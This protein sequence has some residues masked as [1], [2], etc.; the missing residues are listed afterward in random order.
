MRK[1]LFLILFFLTHGFLFA[2]EKDYPGSKDHPVLSRYPG[3]RIV[4]YY[5]KEFEEFS[6]LLGPAKDI[7]TAKRKNL[8]GKL[9]YIKYLC[10]PNKTTLEVYK[11]YELALMKAGFKILYK[12]RADGRSDVGA[13]SKFLEEVS[14]IHVGVTEQPSFY[15]S[16][17]SPDEKIFI[18]LFVTYHFDREPKVILSVIEPKPMEI[19]LV[20]AE[21]ITAETMEAQIKETGKVAIYSIY[22]DFDKADIKPESRPTIEEIAKLLK[23]NPN[24]K[25]YVVEHTDNVGTLEY[26]MKLSERRAQ[27]VVKELVEKY[28]ISKDRL[29][30]FGVGP[31]SPVNTNETEEG[32]ALNR[33][34]ELVKQ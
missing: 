10:P 26:N 4:D 22:F 32:R 11:N 1:I 13:I 30:A 2:E 27:A 29:K 8:E 3:C 9:T 34:V 7:N 31:L 20:K 14:R 23:N 12:E 21:I 19:G 24:L 18:S 16:A 25:L 17:S 15:I 33:R 6:L 5:Q 28:G